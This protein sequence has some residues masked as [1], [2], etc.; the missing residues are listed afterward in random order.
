MKFSIDDPSVIPQQEPPSKI[1]EFAKGA[2]RQIARSGARAFESAAGF[3]GDLASTISSKVH[4]RG[5]EVA[6]L[7]EEMLPPTKNPALLKQMEGLKTGQAPKMHFPGEILPTSEGIR[8]F[9]KKHVAPGGYLEPQ[10]KWEE[11]ADELIQNIAPMLIPGFGIGSKIGK[12]AG[13]MT[14]FGKMKSAV[15]PVGKIG[16]ILE[17][18]LGQKINPTP[19]KLGF[20]ER[21]AADLGDMEKTRA[22]HKKVQ[23]SEAIKLGGGKKFGEW[24]VSDVFGDKNKKDQAVGGIAGM[25]LAA[26]G[27]PS[28]W[29]SFQSKLSAPTK[30]GSSF[31]AT[32][33][34]I[35]SPKWETFNKHN[36][37]LF[38]QQMRESSGIL[39]WG[40]RQLDRF[41]GGKKAAAQA[42]DEITVKTGPGAN[43][44]RT[45]KVPGQVDNKVVSETGWRP[46]SITSSIFGGLV[47]HAAG[48][49]AKK[50]A[51]IGIAIG[52]AGAG[53]GFLQKLIGTFKKSAPLRY[54]YG[55]AMKAAAR[56]SAPA[57][58]N[59]VK[60]FD[61][62]MEKYKYQFEPGFPISVTGPEEKA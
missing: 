1:A 20:K 13:M 48:S 50:A 44:T 31:G 24:F 8:E 3:P 12:S 14:D 10:G 30:E 9:G 45:M 41:S 53:L 18:K 40:K 34:E 23:L 42:A 43:E 62:E 36:R 4:G 46:S 60:K 26:V 61:R 58:I 49:I 29:K 39:N 51:P 22:L 15:Q 33:G 21:I 37:E 11:G 17:N 19:K 5:D 7:M 38:E 52:T 59:N 2:T 54:H 35:N 25:L 27:S 55:Q 16:K 47:G 57:F 6:K 56:K 32:V 28:Q